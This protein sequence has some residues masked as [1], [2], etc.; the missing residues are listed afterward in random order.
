MSD[1]RELNEENVG[2][3]ILGP[4]IIGGAEK[5][6]ATIFNYLNTKH[7]NYS[8]L[9][10]ET[11]FNLLNDAKVFTEKKNITKIKIPSD[12]KEIKYSNPDVNNSS[13]RKN[14]SL[15]RKILSSLKSHLILINVF[16]KIEGW[17]RK[18]NIDVI[19]G[20]FQGAIYITPYYFMKSVKTVISYNDSEFNLLNNR[21]FK[22]FAGF[23]LPLKRAGQVDLLSDFIDE[24]LK[25]RGYNIEKSRKNVANVSFINNE[26]YRPDYPKENWVVFLGRLFD[27]KNPKLFLEASIRILKI[28]RDYKFFILGKGNLQNEL[29]SMIN[30]EGLND[31]IKLFYEPEP[32]KILSKSKI[33]V[34]LQETNNYPS[35][36]LLEAVACEN[37]VIATDVGETRKI[38]TNET[39]ILINKSADELETA[40][41]NLMNY[42][43]IRLNYIK[44]AKI[45]VRE[46]HNI[47]YFANYLINVFK[48]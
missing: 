8:L 43:E 39:G 36:S 15:L 48:K 22:W 19:F 31:Y 33:F 14:D 21:G 17:R 42:E 11:R 35:Q 2:F 23:N 26:K 38:V 40:M 12:K 37:A 4:P 34:S 10:N 30:Q 47:E 41:L 25:K 5:R 32:S 18:N 28:R 16:Y 3:V 46:N 7:N 13:H 6:Y 29:I 1:K 9:I 24:G 20:V 27:Y 44:N 45:K